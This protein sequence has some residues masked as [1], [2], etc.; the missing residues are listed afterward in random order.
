TAKGH[1]AELLSFLDDYL[2]EWRNDSTSVYYQAR[3]KWGAGQEPEEVIPV[4]VAKLAVVAAVIFISGLIFIVLLRHRVNRA[5]G[6]LQKSNNMIRLLL[7]STAEGIYGLDPQGICT[8]CNEASL[9]ILG[10]DNAEQVL[11]QNMHDLIHHSNSDE[12]VM[13]AAECPLLQGLDRQVHSDSEVF[14]RTDGS[15]FPVEYWSYPIRQHD[16]IFGVVISFVDITERQRTEEALRES[17]ERFKKMFRNHS[18]VMLLVKPE[19]GEIFDANDAA[20]KFYKYSREEL[21]SLNI[22]HINTLAPDVVAAERLAAIEENRNHFIFPHRLSN[23]EIRT[24]E[25]HSTPITGNSSSLLFSIV[26]DIT[27]RKQAEEALKLERDNTRNILATVDAMIV[28]LGPEGRI[29]L[30]NRKACEI[31]GYREDELLGQD[32]FATCLPH[33]I[34]VD[35]VRAVFKMALADNLVGSEYYENPVRTRS[36]E[37]RLIAW[38]NSSIRDKEGNII[39]GLTAGVDITE[40]KQAQLS[41]EQKNQELEQLAYSVSHDLK[42]PLITV[43]TYAGML[44]QDLQNGDQPQIN[45]DLNYIDKAADKIQQLLDALLQYSRIGTVDTQAQTLSADQA[46]EDCLTALAGILQKHDVK[47][48]NSE[49]NQQLHG[50]P[51]YFAQVW[52]NLIEN[53]V[54]YS[55]DQPHPL[56][57][58]GAMQQGQDVVFYVR[59]NGIGIAPEH[60]DRIFNLFS[61]LNQGSEGSGLGLALVKKIISIYQGRIWVESAGEGQGSCFMF[62]LPGALVNRKATT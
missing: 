19:T 45:Q 36:G 5:T 56:I 10:F 7:D 41:L 50:N 22:C 31:L 43:K 1:H 8:F 11:G 28:A 26:H 51:L 39:G 44:R 20:V 38:H 46:V 33:S 35:Q 60:N 30:V 17:E 2:L 40:R 18:A 62:T 49:L 61:Q 47:V 6:E 9:R 24:V 42:S 23:G 13:P 21:L 12:T 37:E 15:C 4:W 53:S 27:E 14:W 54:K 55:G 29:T 58:I 34:N 57:E 59:D 3:L 25:V 48:S 32:W 52:Q 16:K